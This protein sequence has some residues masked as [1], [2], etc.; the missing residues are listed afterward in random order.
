MGEVVWLGR[1]PVKS[2]GG[3]GLDEADLDASGV[4]GD[5]RYALIDEETGLIASAK[6]PRKWRSLLSMTAWH[7]PAGRVA[8]TCP[9]GVVIQADAPTAM[10]PG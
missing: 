5:R 2:M 1:Y 10:H 6:N 4:E 9:D 7:R 8:I 3:E